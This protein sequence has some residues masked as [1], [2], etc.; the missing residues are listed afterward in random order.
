MKKE[1]EKEIQEEFERMDGCFSG[2]M[3]AL[4]LVLGFI[5][6]GCFMHSRGC[7]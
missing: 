4:I 2:L 6:V 3:F 7:N 5:A 1:K